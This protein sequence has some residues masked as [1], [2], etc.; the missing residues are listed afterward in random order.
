MGRDRNTM[1]IRCYKF[2]GQ[3]VRYGVIATRIAEASIDGSYVRGRGFRD[4]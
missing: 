4:V 3:F 1:R 2:R